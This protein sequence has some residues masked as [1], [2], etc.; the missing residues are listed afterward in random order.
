MKSRY[1]VPVAVGVFFG[2]VGS[3]SASTITL[4]GTIRDFNASHIDMEGTISGLQTGLV[5]SP[6]AVDKNPVYIGVGGGTVAA[7][8]INSAASFN[9]WYNDVAGVNMSKTYGITLD[10]TITAD[11]KVYTFVSNSFFPIDGDLFGNEGRS[12]NY[13]FTY[14]LHTN[15]TYQGDETF[16]FTGDDDL[17]VYINNQLVIDLGG[18]HGAASGS[19][20]LNSLGL[21][22]GQTYDFDLFFAE[23]HT[24]ESNFRID[25]SIALTP[26]PVPEP[27]SLLL[28]GTGLA[29]LAAFTRRKR[30]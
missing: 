24:S 25:T 6:L 7:G 30:N 10:N 15:F 17:W 22:E 14:E 3:A 2:V 27:V 11:P 4:N 5:S 20:N 16:S 9:Q 29:G 28:F 26:N 13:H 23:R 18:V 8:G 21:T 12:H 19:V 1:F